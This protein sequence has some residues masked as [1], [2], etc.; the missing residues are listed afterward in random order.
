M[1]RCRDVALVG[2]RGVDVLSRD[3]GLDKLKIGA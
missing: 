3:G 2:G 1:F